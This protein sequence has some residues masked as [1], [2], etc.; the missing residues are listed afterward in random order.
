M[1][2]VVVT[3]EKLVAIGDALRD[4][5]EATEAYSLDEMPEVIQ[6]IETGGG[7]DFTIN[8]ASYLFYNGARFEYKDVFMNA[9]TDMGLPAS[10]VAITMQTDKVD[11]D[12]VRVYE[13]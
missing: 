9:L 3:K 4:K 8:D 2:K 7:A 11:F 13:K 12:E 5:T 10:R 6:G 1:S